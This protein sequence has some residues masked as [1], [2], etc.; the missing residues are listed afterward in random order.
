MNKK[1]K[2]SLLKV[3]SGVCGN[4]SAGWFGLILIAPSLER[5]STPEEWIALTQSL[6]FG[7]LFMIFAFGLERSVS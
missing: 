3:V 4:L 5:L 6:G 1:D 2:A 7:I